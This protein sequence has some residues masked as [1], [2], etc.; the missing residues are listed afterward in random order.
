M[1]ISS[2]FEE[3]IDE[4]AEDWR[5]VPQSEPKTKKH[6]HD[7]VHGTITLEAFI[8][9]IVDL[10]PVQRL[11]EIS[12][13]GPVEHVYP[14]ANHT[15]F[16]HSLG[17]YHV[18]CQLL[19]SIQTYEYEFTQ[20]QRNEI[21]AAAILHDIGHLPFSH[22]PEEFLI[23]NTDLKKLIADENEIAEAEVVDPHEYIA[24]KFLNHNYFKEK[25]EDINSTYGKRLDPKKISKRILGQ[26]ET[27]EFTFLTQ[28]IHGTL[29]ADRIDYSLRDAQNIGLPGLVDTDR[30]YST[31]KPVPDKENGAIK[32]GI[33][34]KGLEAAKSLLLSRDRTKSVAHRHHVTLVAEEKI[35]RAIDEK[36]GSNPLDLIGLT[37]TELK[38]KLADTD[39]FDEYK[40]R[41]LPKRYISFKVQA[42]DARL[43][44]DDEVNLKKQMNAEK[45]ISDKL[46]FQA[47]IIKSGFKIKGK[48]DPEE[49]IVH[50]EDEMDELTTYQHDQTLN[51]R[52]N[53]L[54]QIYI[55][56]RHLKSN[57]GDKE[58]ENIKKIVADEFGIN[59]DDICRDSVNHKT[60]D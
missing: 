56:W 41:R 22:L 51:E 44:I 24:F 10:P 1:G 12:Q 8:V 11:R 26:G 31:L 35:R 60:Y 37:D 53:H 29:D 16:E 3:Q 28:I 27:P 46:G 6:I 33:D 59:E 30:L 49:I 55:D 58:I 36:F 34:K 43:T 45:A 47:L 15:R 7:S 18:A 39:I 57:P 14:T 25:I 52:N 40:F 19:E 2:Q 38:N 17:V 20:G 54:L 13:L 48:P 9:A 42:K 32:I 5:G 23:E 50:S 21:K 4:L